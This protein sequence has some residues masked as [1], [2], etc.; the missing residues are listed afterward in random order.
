MLLPLEHRHTHKH[1]S[2][3]SCLWLFRLETGVVT[4]LY[5][6][7]IVF[8]CLIITTTSQLHMA[9]NSD[10]PPSNSTVAATADK[11]TPTSS[12]FLFNMVT[13]YITITLMAFK[14]VYGFRYLK[15]VLFLGSKDEKY[16]MDQEGQAKWE[17]R[18]LTT[19]RKHMQDYYMFTIGFQR[20][21]FIQSIALIL[22]F[23]D[24]LMITLKIIMVLVYSLV[25]YFYMVGKMKQLIKEMN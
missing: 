7:L 22:I 24:K 15:S 17:L 4:I 16:I 14:L 23:F 18:N 12:F 19:Q 3:N 13:D 20:F 5:I 11:K 21:S 1:K 6:D 8:L 10:Q 2:K 9:S 25:T